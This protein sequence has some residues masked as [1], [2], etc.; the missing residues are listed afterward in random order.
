MRLPF[1]KP[2]RAFPEF[3]SMS[4][5]EC[6]QYVH[7]AFIHRPWLTTRLPL[8]LGA[9]TLV[10]WPIFVLLMMEF[11]PEVYSYVPLPTSA[12]GK[13]IFLV[14]T[15]VVM[16][17][18]VPLLVRDLG[19]YLGLK[20]EVNRAR[21]RKCKQ[22]LLGVPLQSIGAEPDPAKQF[23][24]C[25]ECGRK[26]VLMELGLTPRDLVPFEQRGVPPDFAK[27]RSSAA[28]PR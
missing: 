23:I 5:E 19:V 17:V 24:R 9:L 4:D 18:A 12:D 26:F 21:C 14:I 8:L 10:A 6:R 25:P 2:Y 16:A 7:R 27:K 1:S 28:W 3:D 22:S 15:T 11:V 20:D 13:A